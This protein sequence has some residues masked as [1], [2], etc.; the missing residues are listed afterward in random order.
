MSADDLGHIATLVRAAKRFPS[1]RQCLL[2]RALR[3]A[4]QA[5]S[6]NAEN[7]LAIRWL[8]VIWWQLGERRRGRALLYAAEVKALRGV[9]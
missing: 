4:Q 9:S 8:G 3:I 5:L 2:G 6:C 7:H 1:H